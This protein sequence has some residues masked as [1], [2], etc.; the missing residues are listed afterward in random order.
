MNLSSEF[1]NLC[2]ELIEPVIDI[3]HEAGVIIMDFYCTDLSISKKHDFT[4]V[5][6]ADLQAHRLICKRLESLTPNIPVLS[7]ESSTITYATRQ[8][9]HRYWLVD[10]L[11]GTKEF[12]NQ[13]D[14]FT[15]NIAL[16]ENHLPIL[17]V[18][19]EPVS[20]TCYYAI[21]QQPAYK[22]MLSTPA[23]QI[24]TRKTSLDKICIATSRYHNQAQAF[25]NQFKN[26]EIVQLSSSKKIC[27]IAEGKVDVY[28]RNG[29]TSE[30]DTAAAHCVLSRAGGSIMDS[31]LNSLQYNKKESLLNPSFLAVGD[32][33]F[34]WTPYLT[35]L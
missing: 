11:D 2:H 7:E 33:D 19:Q 9:W 27:L 24:A 28:L 34:D 30:W 35:Q 23:I 14:G 18:V 3:A 13:N 6:E 4:P 5:T 8:N 25:I 12:I 20:K 17:G 15:V 1:I 26:P 16:I 31:G 22:K 29:P 21:W 32:P 10:P